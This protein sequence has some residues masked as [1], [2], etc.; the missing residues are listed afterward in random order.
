MRKGRY[1]CHLL[2]VHQLT[3]EPGS[4]SRWR[5]SGGDPQFE[6][7]FSRG[8]LAPGRYRLDL[9]TT[10]SV[11]TWKEASLYV[12]EGAGF[13]E[14]LRFPLLFAPGVPGLIGAEFE[15]LRPVQRL[16][17]DPR[18]TSGDFQLS[19]ADVVLLEQW[20]SALAALLT[21]TRK[22]IQQPRSA[23][24]D[25]RAG[26]AMLFV[27][28]PAALIRTM[29]R[30]DERPTSYGAWIRRYDTLT[31]DDIRHIAVRISEMNDR[32]LISVLMPVHNAPPQYLRR[33]IDSVRAQL[34][35]R[36]EL[37]IA[38]DGS[39]NPATLAVLESYASEDS[40][41]RVIFRETSGHISAASNSA[42]TLVTGSYVA[43][44]DH[45]DEI[46][47]HALYVVADAITTNPHADIVYSDEDKIDAQGNRFG[48][49][50][51]CAWNPGLFYS[52]NLIS[53][54][55]VYRTDLVRRVGG[56]REGYEGSQ[57]YDLALRCL[58][59]SSPDRIVHLPF[60]LYHWRAIPG[61][62]AVSIAEKDYAATA[63]IR[64]LNDHFRRL[65]YSGEA[66]S[67][68]IR[69]FNRA[70]F[71]LPTP[72]PLVSVIIPTRDAPD[73]LA[74][75]V[76]S[77]LEKTTYPALEILIVDNGT[78]DATALSHLEQF[79]LDPRVR[80]LKCEQRFNYAAINNLAVRA[81]K[82]R[83][84]C[85]LNNA[86]EVITPSWLEE[87]VSWAALRGIGAVGAKLLYPDGTIQHAG[88]IMGIM[89]VA[90]HPFRR[91]T[92][93]DYGYFGRAVV[94]QD[95]SAVT[96]ACLVVGRD[97]FE[98]V[99]GLNEREL[100]VAFNDIDLCLRLKKAGYR[101]YWTPY[102]V[103]CH[104]ESASRGSEDSVEKQRRFQFEIAHMKRT[105]DAEIR[106]DPAYSP[107]LTLLKED[108][109]L[110]FPP[111]VMK[112]W[113]RP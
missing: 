33:A 86:V 76:R 68:P 83:I 82:G 59:Q 5:A 100:T 37:C 65:D 64:A 71:R 50:F 81:S 39:T 32:P 12:D 38:D 6:L 31:P 103:L 34:Y 96:G 89:G 23:A 53:H 61:S 14:W 40:R 25:L 78:T 36:W 56:F 48:P 102:A 42:L 55:G 105:W 51:K 27:A 49:Y 98:A 72:P 111:R 79:R 8:R 88:V 84:L 4:G 21:F 41:I 80:L 1:R 74:T 22:A 52:Q 69:G 58:E 73:L 67:S 70:C 45:D 91:R 93:T 104:H 28:G 54:L 95:V 109:G 7:K 108:Y 107:N 63:A 60:V 75:C 29:R 62:T 18:T 92:G 46:P 2:P 47:R 94:G 44:M 30:L 113:R 101:N 77:V 106:D 85:L 17:L 9:R 19:G 87:L 110:A 112:P 15:T 99:G 16:R 13:S 10:D 97:A 35:D 66:V 24:V 3:R 20:G 43:L 90:G 11:S 57:D 26:L